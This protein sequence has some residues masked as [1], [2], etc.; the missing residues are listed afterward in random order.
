M[1]E[2]QRPLNDSFVHTYVPRRDLAVLALFFESN[3]E[4]AKSLS[5]LIRKAV[6]YFSRIC[7]ENWE[8]QDIISSEE[9][10]RVLSSLYPNSNLNRGGRLMPAYMK[11]LAKEETI[12]DRPRTPAV[13]RTYMETTAQNIESQTE[14]ALAEFRRMIANEQK[15]DSER[16]DR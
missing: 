11:N 3:R 7:V 1:S 14:K 8:A 4:P 10:T 12:L 16:T 2:I 15:V 13:Q 5:D 9:A 6:Y